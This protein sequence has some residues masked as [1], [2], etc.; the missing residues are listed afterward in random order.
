M[1][2]NKSFLFTACYCALLTPLFS[3]VVYLTEKQGSYS[4]RNNT[5][6]E[7]REY[8][9]FGNNVKTVADYFH[10]NIPVMKANK[11]FDLS[12]TLFGIG[13]ETYTNQ[14]SNYG[15][16]GE[17]TFDFQL[18]LKEEK[19]VEK[20]WT[21]E[22]PHFEF[23]I[24]DTE[25][26]HGGMLNEGNEGSFL[27]KLFLVFPMVKELSAGVRYY[28]CAPRTCGS[29][30][31]FNP[32]RPNYWLTV[33]V[34]EVVD[35]KLKYYKETDKSVYNF[36]KPLVDNMGEDE[37]NAPA[38]NTS[39]DG[40]LQVNGKGIGLQIMRFNAEYWNRNLSSSAVQFVS[41]IYS[42]YGQGNFNVDDQKKDEA[43]YLKNNGHPNYA[44]LVK[45]M[46][47]IKE[48]PTLIQKSTKD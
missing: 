26:G 13:G 29:L 15:L 47:T 2:L 16:R 48:L 4:F 32:D 28:D 7:G 41:I 34:R 36:I 17:L 46:L 3:Q 39:D 18:F 38:Y 19:G 9:K 12:A 30:V 24:N 23:Y 25:A 37:L 35:A 20:K 6:S 21:V 40:I 42:E 45:K 27:K 1:S 11:G 10:Q 33:T 43:E 8:L 44:D 14:Q 31:V 22:P 5:A